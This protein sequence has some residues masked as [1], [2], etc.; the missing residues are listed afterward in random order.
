MDKFTVDTGS[1]DGFVSHYWQHFTIEAIR[2]IAS[3]SQNDIFN[4]LK[5]LEKYQKFPL[6]TAGNPQDDLAPQDLAAARTAL[7]RVAGSTVAPA[8]GAKSIGLGTLTKNKDIDEQLDA[9]RGTNL[10]R[11]KLDYIAALQRLFAGLPTDASKPFT[12]SVTVIKEHLKDDNSVSQKYHDMPIM[13]GN[14]ALAQAYLQGIDPDKKADVAYPGADLNLQ[15][16]ETPN[17]PIVQTVSFPGP[18][19]AL[20]LLASPKVDSIQRDGTKWTVNFIVTDPN[21]KKW[22]LWLLLDFKAELPDL[23]DWPVPPAKASNP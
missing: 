20:R 2:V 10:L 8:G 22:S 9:L 17:G 12:V 16:R 5:D 4:G 19:G 6:A 21:N 18:W 14:Q 1:D 11:G 13:Q 3:D 7:D 15:F 23:K